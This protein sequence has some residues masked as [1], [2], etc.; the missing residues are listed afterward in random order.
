MGAV[1]IPRSDVMPLPWNDQDIVSGSSPLVTMHDTWANPS[2][3]ITSAPKVK[4]SNFGGS[5]GK[6]M[7]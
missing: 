3:S 7:C 6:I 5:D 1:M 2:S 4:G